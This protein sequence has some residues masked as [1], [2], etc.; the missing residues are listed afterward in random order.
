MTDAEFEKFLEFAG[1]S[2]NGADKVVQKLAS[3]FDTPQLRRIERQLHDIVYTR[4][5]IPF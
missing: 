4:E 1:A 5:R 3:I 2:E